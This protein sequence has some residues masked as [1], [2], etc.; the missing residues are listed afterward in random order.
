MLFLALALDRR[1]YT[2]MSP[3][4]AVAELSASCRFDAHMMEVLEKY[5]PAEAEFEVRRLPLRELRSSMVL[6]QDVL[7]DDRNLLI[8]KAGTTLNDTW[9]E[10][11]DNFATFRGMKELV[12]VRVPTF[13][14]AGILD[15]TD[16]DL[17]ESGR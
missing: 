4:S 13:A 2:G 6:L 1:I 10:R 16:Y 9:I 3:R 14:G 17:P 12:E 7:S 8:L 5:S 15:K 11:L